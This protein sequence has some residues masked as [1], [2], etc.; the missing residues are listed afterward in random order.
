MELVALAGIV[1]LAAVLRLAWA[2]VNSFAFDEAHLSLIALEMGRGGQFARVGMPS[3]AGVP[4]LP[5]AAWVFSLPYALSPDPLVATQFVGLLSLGVVI[6]TWA[7]AR[8]VW[9]TWAGLAAALFLAASPYAALY[10]RS[11][12]AQNLLPVLG[13][14]WGWTAFTA[15]TRQSKPALAA[16]IFL[17]GFAFQVH[18]AGAALILPSLYFFL[19]FRWWR[20]LVPVLIGGGLALLALLP[21]VMEIACCRPDVLDQYRGALGGETQYDLF[22]FVQLAQIGLGT[23]WDYLLL[24]DLQPPDSPL[25]TVLVGALLLVGIL[26]CVWLIFRARRSAVRDSASS[27][28]AAVLAE[29]MLAWL[30]ASPLFFL[31]HS[32]PVMIHYHLAALPALALLAGAASHLLAAVARR[33]RWLP[34]ALMLL[35]A[36]AWTVQIGRGLT[37]A[38]HSETPNGLGTPLF[39]SR[40]AAYGVPQDA[41]VLFF[42][43]GD[44]PGQHGEAAAFAALWWGRDYRL[45]QGESLL[46]LP[47]HPAWLMATLRPFQAWEEIED[48]GL[49]QAVRTFDRREGAAPFV[50]T[51]YDGET[52]PAGFRPLETPVLLADD[53]QLE[54]WKAR[55]VGPRLRISTLWRVTDLPAAGVIQQFHHL[56]TAQTLD[57]D[58]PDAISDVPIAAHR[59]QVGDR[60]IVMG[61][62]FIDEAG[63][64]W[65]DVGHYTLPDVQRI[66]R[67][68]GDEALIRLGPFEIMTDS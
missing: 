10:A 32:T 11:V 25:L 52:E 2:G 31:R 7:L 68:D 43:H 51:R 54:G 50:L 63:P 39:H 61:D 24:G 36:L 9:G 53:T 26:A 55:R 41:P 42:T 62:F 19:R 12:W 65:V 59:W 60:L 46:I 38:G 8:R 44:D 5:A 45:V 56:R 4:N 20:R 13:L 29:I 14:A 64:F 66:P 27:S 6:G 17:A 1:L 49:A 30:V 16:H 33:A 34:A 58:Q 23:N 37:M 47:D 57:S 67:A 35:V 15:I 28:D 48:A 3:S 18:F 40:N 21:F 22:G